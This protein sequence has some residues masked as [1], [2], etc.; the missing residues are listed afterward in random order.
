[1]FSATVM[2]G[3]SACDWNTIETLRCSGASVRPGEDTTRSPS[4]TSPAV[5]SMKPATRR[6]AVVF[7]QPE[8]PRRQTSCPSW[9]SRETPSSAVWSPN[10]LVRPRKVTDD[11]F[12]SYLPVNTGLR[13]SKNACRPST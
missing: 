3:H 7:P 10:R 2:C 12:G 6:S 5:G 4:T 8:G 11:T 9:I 1:M 13:F